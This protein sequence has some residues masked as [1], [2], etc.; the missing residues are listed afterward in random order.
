MI[1]NYKNPGKMVGNLEKRAS[2]SIRFSA[3][4]L[5][6]VTMQQP[7]NCLEGEFFID[8]VEKVKFLLKCRF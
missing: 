7:L 4:Y 6:A 8:N 3:S 2:L 5:G 1:F